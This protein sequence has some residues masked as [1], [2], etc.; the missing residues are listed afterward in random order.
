MAVPGGPLVVPPRPGKSSVKLSM[1]IPTYNEARNVQELVDMLRVV[2]TAEVGEAFELILVDD[3][4]PDGTW[5]SG[6]W[7]SQARTLE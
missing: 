5:Q 3:D 4:S 2:L 1:V 6:R 7:R